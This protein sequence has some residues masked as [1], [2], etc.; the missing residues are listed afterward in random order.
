M[1]NPIGRFAVSLM[2]AGLVACTPVSEN[3]QSASGEN[4]EQPP[5]LRIAIIGDRTGGH[6]PD[7]FEDALHKIHNMQPDLVL[8]VGDLVEGY[9][10]DEKELAR[11]WNEVEAELQ[12][13]GSRFHAVPG[14]HDYSN[15]VMARIWRERRG[16]AYWSLVKDDVLIL[17]LSTE[18]P[19][20]PLPQSAME[21]HVRLQQAMARD[22]V[23]T[24]KR[25]LEATR[26]TEKGAKPGEVSISSEQVSYFRKV[27][28]DNASPRW[29]FILMH[30]PAWAYESA[31][32]QELEALLADRPYTVI[33]GHEHYYDYAARNGRDYLTL[34][35]TGGV[36]LKDGPGKVDHFLWVAVGEGEPT[37][38]NI[39]I[40]GIFDRKGG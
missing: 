11:Q 13:F 22:P 18:D 34:G 23:G 14:N 5:V 27:L 28:A 15:A 1:R 26:G 35:T 20:I 32:F 16:P 31:E 17:G 12:K 4:I 9:I 33:A 38:S 10:K 36:W 6:R 3:V 7:V 21:G 25:I 40:D 24:Q 39:E 19:P 8:S 37:F 30:K 29:T 2:L